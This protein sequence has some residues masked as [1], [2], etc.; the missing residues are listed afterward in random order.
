MQLSNLSAQL[1]ITDIDLNDSQ[2]VSRIV[3]EFERYRSPL[4]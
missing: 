3:T 4:V 1:L 2:L